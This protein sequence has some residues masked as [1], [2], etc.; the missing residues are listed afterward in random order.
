MTISVERQGGT[1]RVGVSGHLIVGNRRQFRRLVLDALEQ[2]VQHFVVDLGAM[3]YVDSAGLGTLVML[4]RRVSATGGTLQLVNLNEAVRTSIEP[5]RFDTLLAP[6]N[7][8]A[9][10]QQSGAY[11][12]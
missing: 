3:G 10:W 2:G 6:S 8:A 11:V 1:A 12:D 5:M 4:A 7:S 9:L